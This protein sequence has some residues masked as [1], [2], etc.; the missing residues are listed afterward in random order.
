MDGLLDEP[1]VGA[2][3][4][5]TDQQIEDVITKTLESMPANS[6]HWSTRLMAHEA[7]LTQNA[8]VRIWRAFG[9]QPHRV[10]EPGWLLDPHRGRSALGGGHH[11]HPAGGGIRVPGGDS[12]CIFPEGDRMASGPDAGNLTDCGGVGDGL[13][14]TD[15]ESGTG[16]SLRSRSAVCQRGIYA[17]A[18][19]QRHPDQH[20][21]QGEPLGQRGLRIVYED[22]EV[23]RGVSDRIRGSG[24]RPRLARPFS[25]KGK[26]R[27]ETTPVA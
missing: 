25:E 13:T 26:K 18:V 1:R 7:G 5:I 6:T 8:I 22:I 12:G 20:E 11:L 21:P 4:K 23:R 19:G 16:P 3:R 27:K 2:P 17:T 15:G 10:S 9:L 14:R 24:P